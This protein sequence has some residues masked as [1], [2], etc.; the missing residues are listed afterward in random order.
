MGRAEVVDDCCCELGT[1]A[2]VNHDHLRPILSE[3]VAHTFFNYF[4]LN[5]YQA[6][7]LLAA[8]PWSLH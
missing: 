3:L 6:R 7:M 2:Q 1:L 4:K 8:W 5:L